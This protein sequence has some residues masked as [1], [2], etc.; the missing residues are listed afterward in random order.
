MALMFNKNASSKSLIFAKDLFFSG[1]ETVGQR[2]NQEDYSLFRTLNGGSNLLAVMADG[3]G[4][5]ASGEVASKK[6]VE[7]FN[8][9]FASF[10]LES[11]TARLAAALQ[12]ANAQIAQ[13][14]KDV[15]ALD[16]MGCTM[17]A[18]HL[19][20][21]G[22]HWISVGDSILY[23]LRKNKLTR[24]N[25]DHSMMSLIND[26]VR[27]GKMSEAEASNYPYRN[28]LRSAVTGGEISLI[29]SP[30]VPFSLKR[31]DIV[32]LATDGILSISNS[33]I[34]DV[35]KS[36][37]GQSASDMASALIRKVES[38]RKPKQDNTSIQVIIVPDWVA[39]SKKNAL[40]ITLGLLLATL[41]ASVSAFFI[42]SGDEVRI[43]SIENAFKQ[44]EP[45]RPQPTL[46]P[47]E[48][49]QETRS[50]NNEKSIDTKTNQSS[51]DKSTAPKNGKAQAPQHPI[52]RT[53]TE[54]Q[55]EPVGASQQSL[56]SSAGGG[57]SQSI[58]QDTEKPSEG[59]QK[60][61]QTNSG[62]RST[63][64]E[65]NCAPVVESS[66]Q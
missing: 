55:T 25:D 15:P 4:G 20:L 45:A 14:I 19:G 43:D 21:D 62:C 38:K 13:S 48:Q 60:T 23:V 47:V 66:S 9:A 5:H 44:P 58:K 51:K 33:E 18:A 56:N 32:V 61:T 7:A 65:D 46:V 36:M 50:A 16:G 12:H 26:S 11:V 10:P 29:D 22:L 28:A 40:K 59:Q 31:G 6:A 8:D 52:K 63:S 53:Q 49:N 37:S 17:V 42:Y 27:S 35:L 39:K 64:K 24:L 2:E 41:M 3:M 1:K 54:I 57:A 34:V 30:A